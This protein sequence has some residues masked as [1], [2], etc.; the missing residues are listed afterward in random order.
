M[1]SKK[2]NKGSL[3]KS[4]FAEYCILTIGLFILEGQ[5]YKATEVLAA[6]AILLFII[7]FFIYFKP[8][9]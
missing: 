8:E 2:E 6:G 4:L 7:R 1:S 3:T 5:K 9:K